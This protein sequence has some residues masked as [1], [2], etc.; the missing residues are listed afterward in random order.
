[1]FGNSF[2]SGI[3]LSL[4]WRPADKDLLEIN[5]SAAPGDGGEAGLLRSA[6]LFLSLQIL[7]QEQKL[8]GIFPKERGN[9]TFF[10]RH[11]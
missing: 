5:P 10:D 3:L 11:G 8:W 1:M 2:I 9:K 7:L 4:L 6:L